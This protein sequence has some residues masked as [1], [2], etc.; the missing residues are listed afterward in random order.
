MWVGDADGDVLAL[1]ERIRLFGA[2]GV[3]YTSHSYGH[4]KEGKTEPSRGG[5]VL[6]VGDRKLAQEE[7]RLADHAINHLFGGEF[8][9]ARKLPLAVLW[10]LRTARRELPM[11]A[12]HH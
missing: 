7:Y 3:I 2:A 5:R 11:Q 4:V 10:R 6:L 8:D 12:H 1:E 9:P